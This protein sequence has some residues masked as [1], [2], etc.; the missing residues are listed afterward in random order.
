MD[1][2]V[3]MNIHTAIVA[4]KAMRS[5]CQEWLLGIKMAAVK[6]ND[7]L[8]LECKQEDLMIKPKIKSSLPSHS[9][10]G[11]TELTKTWKTTLAVNQLQIHALGH[12]KTLQALNMFG[13]S[14]SRKKQRSLDLAE[15]GGN[16]AC[17]RLSWAWSCPSTDGHGYTWDTEWSH[18]QNREGTTV[19]FYPPSWCLNMYVFL[20]SEF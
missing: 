10:P 9:P 20:F 13:K 16:P 3:S 15:K 2:N 12:I 14:I 5:G 7:W 11:F 18:I 19:A 17:S 1:V 8:F 6:G 4:Y